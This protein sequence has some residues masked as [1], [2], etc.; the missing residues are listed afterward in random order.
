MD[1]EK[2]L[3]DKE[4][5]LMEEKKGLM[6]KEKGLMEEKKGLTGT[7][8]PHSDS[9]DARQSWW[10]WFKE[11]WRNFAMSLGFIASAVAA[12]ASFNKDTNRSVE[13]LYQKLSNSLAEVKMK[14]QSTH[15]S[16]FYVARPE[17]E[18]KILSVYD[19]TSLVDGTYWIIYG[20][21][22]AGKTSAVNHALGDKAG[23]VLVRVSE[24]DSVQSIIAKIFEAC[25]VVMDKAI[26]LDQINE[27]LYAAMEKRNGHP[28]TVL[29]EVE[30]GSS[31]PDVLSL[32]KHTAKE[33]A[34][35]AN[36]LIVLSEANAV[37]GFD[38][39]DRQKFILVGEMTREEAEQYVKKRAPDISP[40]DFN[41]FADKC[42]TI[43]LMLGQFC[44]AVAMGTNVDKH[45]G[46]VVSKARCKLEGF[47]HSP[48]LIAL[49]KTPGGVR[50]GIFKGV[51]HRGVMLSSPKDVVPAMKLRNAIM[52]DFEAGEY[53]LFSK[54]HQTALE[55]CDPPRSLAN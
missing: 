3:M 2:G 43:P 36:V 34:L 11:D 52:Y 51:E 25:G 24:N 15:A 18:A 41:K 54:A 37:L 14:R 44:T 33:F 10:G 1:K 31:S 48:I 5:G 8:P 20:V 4:K 46:D 47:A 28:M 35:F 38:D 21:K 39:D 49:K 30:R 42:G 6:D 26:G 40:E 32:V 12:S 53:K 22:G 50:S 55:T 9:S 27:E 45:I 16:I 23:V 29:F 19:N 13:V 17:L 7:Q